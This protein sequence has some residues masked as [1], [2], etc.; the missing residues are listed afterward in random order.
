MTLISSLSA[1]STARVAVGDTVFAS[2]HNTLRTAYEGRH[3]D[4]LLIARDIETHWASGTEPGDLVDGKLWYDSTNALLKLRRSSAW[5]TLVGLTQTQ[6]LTN[7]T[8]TALATGHSFATGGADTFKARGVIESNTTAVSRTDAGAMMAYTLP[9]STLS[10]NQVI[11]ITAY[12]T[13]TG[14]GHVLTFRFGTTPTIRS[15]PWSPTS[16]GIDNGATV[17]ICK[18][19]VMRISASAS[20]ITTRGLSDVNGDSIG[21]FNAATTDVAFGSDQI[22]DFYLDSI[23]SGT[24][25]QKGMLI[26]ILN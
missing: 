8:L 22:V 11:R 20:D 23:G 18:A 19:T 1:L 15:Y 6:T 9:A 2:E 17:W 14:N 26:E 25:V 5:E 12:G 7:K 4:I 21:H 13:K 24:I 16:G 10:D 3:N